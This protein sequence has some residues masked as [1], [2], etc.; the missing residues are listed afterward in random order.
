M[1][2]DRR[3]VAQVNNPRQKAADRP[4]GPPLRASLALGYGYAQCAARKPT[5]ATK[6]AKHLGA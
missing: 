1:E 5:T 4:S 2:E 3:A 6:N